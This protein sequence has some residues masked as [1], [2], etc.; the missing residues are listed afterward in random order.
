MFADDRASSQGLLDEGG[1]CQSK[2]FRSQCQRR[3]DLR[4]L[5]D[6]GGGWLSRLANK[7]SRSQSPSSKE[8]EFNSHFAGQ[9]RCLDS[10]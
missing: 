4:N 5:L 3:Y 10:R 8:T 7:S 1:G 2:A 9:G 6:K